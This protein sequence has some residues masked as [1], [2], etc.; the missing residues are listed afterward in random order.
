[1]DVI[2]KNEEHLKSSVEIVKADMNLTI[3]H[4]EM[5]LDTINSDIDRQV[6]IR[7]NERYLKEQ[8]LNECIL[9][10]QRE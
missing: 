6:S 5:E 3:K 7:L 4:L 1:M 8:G 9:K 10:Y 2:K